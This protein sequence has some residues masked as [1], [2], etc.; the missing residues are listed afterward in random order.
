MIGKSYIVVVAAI[1]SILFRVQGFHSISFCMLLALIYL[2]WRHKDSAWIVISSCAIFVF[3]YTN[4][5]YFPSPPKEIPSTKNISGKIISIPKF[6]GSKIIF[7]IKTKDKHKVLINYEAK[8]VEELTYLKSLKYEYV[9]SLS[10]VYKEPSEARNFY[11]FNYKQ[12]LKNKKIFFQFVPESF[13]LSS[14]QEGRLSPLGIVQRYRQQGIEYINEY[15]PQESKGIIIALLFGDRTQ[16]DTTILH[17]Y[18]RLGIIHLLAVSGLH[19]GLVSASL[20]FAMIRIGLTKERTLELL[21]LIMPIYAVLAGGAPSVLRATAM[22]MVLLVSL[23]LKFKLNPLDGISF[24]CLALLIFNPQILFHIGFQ[25]SF[26]VSYSLIISAQ[27]I[28]QQYSN[29][30]VKVLAVTVIAQLISY[31]LIIYHFYEISLWSIPLNLIYIPFITFFTLPFAF[32]IFISHLLFTP[33]SEFLLLFYNFIVNSAHVFL[34]KI[35]SMPYAT[36]TLGKP[37]L[38]FIPLY[39]AAI[40]LM[41]Y[42]WETKHFSNMLKSASMFFIVV[43]FHWY[44]PYLTNEGEVT[45]LDVGQG[46]SILIELPRRKA[47]YLVD[48]GG[49]VNIGF[50]QELVKREREFDVGRDVVVPYLKAKGI[51]KI[52][53][54]ILS[55]GHYDHIGGAQALLGTIPV[56]RILYG[57]VPLESNFEK[58]L[59]DGFR[60]VGTQLVFVT[61]GDFWRLGKNEFF[62]LS[63]HGHEEK[64]NDR[65]IVFLTKLGG[66]VWLFTGDLELEGEKALLAHYETLNIDVLKVAHHGSKTST[67]T[68]LLERTTPT[69]AL[70]SLGRN[71]LYGHPH[72]EVLQR[73]DAHGVTV[74]RTDLH[75][76]IRY[77]FKG[78]HGYFETVMKER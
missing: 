15:F 48:T 53:K 6:N 52:D 60:D 13:Q 36:V 1:C 72:E 64:I 61:Q 50:R 33:L 42:T 74:L 62:I 3:F 39:Y 21:L 20:Y 54:L 59:L 16:I 57:A 51:R 75:G 45:M 47:V 69:K 22:F 73:L 32:I 24:V 68:E 43:L 70:I 10:G 19:V 71:N 14:C 58:E 77:R 2:L 29:W 38:L 65:S 5:Y 63:P 34:L 7:E 37:P 28:I 11:S 66:L 9:C 56:D 12:Y 40:G 8:S 23:R 41:F 27:T 49:L 25:L 76:G 18:Q 44:L 46:D 67:T 31:P 4:P 35:M 17:S 30:I 26:L 78:N 55:H